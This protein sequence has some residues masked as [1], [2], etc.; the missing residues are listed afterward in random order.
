MI[1]SVLDVQRWR[2][3]KP[4]RL[5]V[6]RDCN[7]IFG[8]NAQGKTNLIEAVYVLCLAKSF[9]TREDAELVP[10]D[11]EDFLIDGDFESESGI[12]HHVGVYYHPAQGKQIKLNSKRLGQFSALIGKF[13][14][15]VLSANDYAITTGPPAE[16]RRFFN[17]LLAQGSH[18]YLD[19]LKKYEKILKQRNAILSNIAAG[20]TAAAS[21][22]ELW[23]QQFIEIGAVLI[24]ARQTLVKDLTPIVEEK[25]QALINDKKSFSIG[26]RPNV[27]FPDADSIKDA[28]AA[29]LQ[30]N[31]GRERRQGTSLVGPHRDDFRF[32]IAGY[33]LRKFGSRGEHKSALVGLKAAEAVI[34][35][36][37]TDTAPIL[38]LDDLYAEL[39]KERCRH[40]LEL[41]DADCQLFITGTS[42]D[43][44]ALQQTIVRPQ[45]SQTFFVKSGEVTRGES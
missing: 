39:D 45:N 34:L 10:F 15:V 25:Y 11:A 31:A 8:D 41:F 7:F 12:E 6:H 28:F 19:A 5:Q 9:R 21:Q 18:R 43:H 44:A 2:N 13:P 36:D 20:Q 38:L 26:Y 3:L 42:L 27:E 29:A 23:N 22:L 16:R 30:K 1:L 17:V 35:K 32:N 4:K 37:Q 33:D 14:I 24:R 40:V